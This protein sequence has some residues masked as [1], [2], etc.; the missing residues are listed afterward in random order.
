MPIKKDKKKSKKKTKKTNSL[1]TIIKVVIN[2]DKRD[3]RHNNVN[4]YTQYKQPRYRNDTNDISK[5]IPILSSVI[6]TNKDPTAKQIYSKINKVEELEK[7]LKEKM[8][9]NDFNKGDIKA[10]NNML[11]N[12]MPTS[13]IVKYFPEFE[14]IANEGERLALMANELKNKVE[15]YKE[16]E[17]NYKLLQENAA[18]EY[19]NIKNELDNLKHSLAISS[20]EKNELM[21]KINNL[22]EKFN[23]KKIT[24]NKLKDSYASVKNLMSEI[25]NKNLIF[26][27]ELYNKTIKSELGDSIANKYVEPLD[28]EEKQQYLN[29]H[30]QLRQHYN[31]AYNNKGI[32]KKLKEKGISLKE[33]ESKEDSVDRLS[34]KKAL[35]E[36]HSEGKLHYQKKLNQVGEYPD[37]EDLFNAD[38]GDY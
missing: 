13:E 12:G 20:D 36:L 24:Y 19:N 29:R 14:L 17:S 2:N 31:T 30:E 32:K 25:A 22:N 27:D 15:I 37:V 8:T 11:M 34:K 5:L 9:N 38:E 3:R 6:S 7:K 10:I 26:E 35:D 33:G 28:E 16:K 21:E 4:G 18:D 23:D 1:G